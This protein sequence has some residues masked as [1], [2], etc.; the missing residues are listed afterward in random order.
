MRAER[1]GARDRARA[2]R[3]DGRAGAALAGADAAH[4]RPRRRLLR[5]RRRRR[6]PLLTFFAW[7]V[8][9]PEPR[10]ALRPGQRGRGADHRLPVRARAGHAD[11]DHG[12]DRARRATQRRA[13]PRR[14]GDRAPAH[15]RHAD[16]RQDRHA[17]R[18]QAGVRVASSP[19]PGFERGRGAAPRREP[20]PGR[21]SIR[22]PSAIVRAARERG[23]VAR[24]AR[25]FESS[26]GIG[27]R[28]SVDGRPVALGNTALM[29]EAGVDA[30][31]LADAAPRR[32]ARRAPA[33]CSSPSTASWRACS[34]CRIRSRQPRAEALAALRA[35]GIRVVMATGDGLATA[36]AVAAKLGIDDVH[37]EVAPG[38]QAGAGRAAA[39]RGRTC[40]AMAG[41]GI[42]DAPALA[43]ADVGIAMGTGT[44]VAMQER[45][46]HAGQGRPARHRPRA[47]SSRRR[48]SPT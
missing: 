34:R 35:A 18:R 4:G 48:R 20:R 2:D 39:A 29:A 43:Q 3:A 40:V 41:D 47:R 8:F 10:W 17:H 1:V 5:R 26:S 30:A 36:Q 37:G 46:G 33:S 7:G 32:C 19:S 27:V 25:G 31:A 42:N 23:L 28:G 13:V 22:W 24:Q 38:R 6:S 45:A 12:R 14:R 21:A 9:G 15:G 16:R 44:D 11:V